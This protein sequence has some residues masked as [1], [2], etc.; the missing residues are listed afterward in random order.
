MYKW[1]LKLFINITVN[2]DTIHTI[3]DTIWFIEKST[4]DHLRRK[5]FTDLWLN[6]KLSVIKK[7]FHH[8]TVVL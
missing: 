8:S 3:V 2:I 4:F 7:K 5:Y 6:C 1:N